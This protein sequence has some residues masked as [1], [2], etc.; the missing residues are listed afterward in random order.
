[1]CKTSVILVRVR[2][3]SKNKILPARPPSEDDTVF[4]GLGTRSV[5]RVAINQKAVSP[6]Q[7]QGPSLRLQNH[8]HRKGYKLNA[9]ATLGDQREQSHGSTPNER[10]LWPSLKSL[11]LLAPLVIASF[12]KR[13]KHAKT[14]QGILDKV[15]RSQTQGKPAKSAKSIL[16][17]SNLHHASQNSPNKHQHHSHH[18]IVPQKVGQLGSARHECQGFI[19]AHEPKQ[20]HCLSPGQ[21]EELKTSCMPPSTNNGFQFCLLPVQA[22]STM[23]GPLVACASSPKPGISGSQRSFKLLP[24][25][26]QEQ[27]GSSKSKHTFFIGHIKGV[28]KNA[29]KCQKPKGDNIQELCP[30]SLQQSN[31]KEALDTT[32][33][34]VISPK[35]TNPQ[36]PSH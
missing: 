33:E 6:K 30:T 32:L 36:E 35:H 3:N 34:Y 27:F 9:M 1:M 8:L 14:P 15:P 26:H 18:S 29:L 16:L 28:K 20:T 24:S 23:V 5:T 25:S 31:G 17:V 2:P 12:L 7:S 22:I 13:S 10:K 4:F 21:I 19:A 11:L